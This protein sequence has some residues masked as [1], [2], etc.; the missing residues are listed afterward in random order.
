M[1]LNDPTAVNPAF[2]APEPEVQETIA[3]ELV[4]TNEKGVASESD[5]V[6]ITVNPSDSPPSPPPFEGILGFW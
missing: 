6:T 4:V 3:F 1:A 5:S 2:T